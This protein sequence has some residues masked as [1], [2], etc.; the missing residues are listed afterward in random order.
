ME[1]EEGSGS[2][3]TSS[4]GVDVLADAAQH[5]QAPGTPEEATSPSTKLGLQVMDESTWPRSMHI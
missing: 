3:S 2:N 5:Q 4:D 1:L